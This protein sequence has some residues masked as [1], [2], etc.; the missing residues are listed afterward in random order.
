MNSWGSA[1]IDAEQFF[2]P[3]SRQRGSWAAVA[4]VV[5]LLILGVIAAIFRGLR[6]G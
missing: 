6:N 2:R 1:V 5:A 4:F 3:P